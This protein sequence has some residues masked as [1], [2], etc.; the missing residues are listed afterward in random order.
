MHAYTEG[1]IFTHMFGKAVYLNANILH[2]SAATDLQR[3]GTCNS[4]S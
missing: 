3:G 4:S 2:G 1:G